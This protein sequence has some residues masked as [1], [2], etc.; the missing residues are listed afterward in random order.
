VIRL[1][2]L[3]NVRLYREGLKQILD[4]S[5]LLSVEGT[6]ADPREAINKVREFIPDVVLVDM[7]SIGSLST[8]HE[9]AVSAPTT[10]LVALA[11]P[12]S[13]ES[14]ISC[15]EAGIV[16]FVPR[17]AS[18]ADLTAA[19]ESAMRGDLLCS[20]R[21][22]ATLLKRVAALAPGQGADAGG[23]RLT[24]REEEVVVLL[25][26]GLTNKEIACHLGIEVATVKNHVHNLLEKLKVHRRG[27]AAARMRTRPLPSVRPQL[28]A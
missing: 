8:L 6:A 1:V 4:R 20:P 22:A 28:R 17:E 2:I 14:L 3:A 19:I 7:S 15:A 18:L 25:E 26:S 5:E 9:I 27:Q 13:D 16:G 12:D 21:T 11:V 24:P 23:G 10:K